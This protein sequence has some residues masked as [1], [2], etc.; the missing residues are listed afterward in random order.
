MKIKTPELNPALLE[1]IKYYVYEDKPIAGTVAKDWFKALLNA[2]ASK[3]IDRAQLLEHLE[4]CAAIEDAKEY[5]R[6]A[7]VLRNLAED[8]K[9]GAFDYGQRD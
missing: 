7:I 3:G 8:L 9:D 6:T 2:L 1:Q 5:Q 4:T